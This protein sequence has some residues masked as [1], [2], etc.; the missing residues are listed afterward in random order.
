MNELWKVIELDAVASE[1]YAYCDKLS[2]LQVP[3]ESLKLWQ[4]RQGRAMDREIFNRFF[5]SLNWE[6][7]SK[8]SNSS[9]MFQL[10]SC[11]RVKKEKKR[12]MFKCV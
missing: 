4:A 7:D 5:S 1:R 9:D 2:D 10:V 3:D 11:V 12:D 6:V 8:I